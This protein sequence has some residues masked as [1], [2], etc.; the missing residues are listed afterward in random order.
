MPPPKPEGETRA[1]VKRAPRGVSSGHRP[2]K[3]VTG[4]P[5]PPS[6]QVGLALSA[7]GN[8]GY[9][10]AWS[11]AVRRYRAIRNAK[12]QAET[13]AAAEAAAAPKA[14]PNFERQ[15]SSRLQFGALVVVASASRR[16]IEK[17]GTDQIEQPE[18]FVP[19][20]SVPVLTKRK[21]EEE[22]SAGVTLKRLSLGA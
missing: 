22:I 13:A 14:K 16:E 7:D 18:L 3:Q 15:G 17:E 12:K 6:N 4:M 11:N 5:A 21:S 19:A 20:K 2:K 1:A 9:R 10:V 8:E